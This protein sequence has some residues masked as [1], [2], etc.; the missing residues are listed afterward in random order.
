MKSVRASMSKKRCRLT[1]I[2]VLPDCGL[3]SA[4]ICLSHRLSLQ[5][6]A[7]QAGRVHSTL[8]GITFPAKEIIAVSSDTL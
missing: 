8:Q 1:A 7:D 3:D 4:G 6:I 5:V 2:N